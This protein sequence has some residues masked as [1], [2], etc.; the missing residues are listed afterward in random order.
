MFARYSFKRA[1]FPTFHGFVPATCCP[2][3]LPMRQSVGCLTLFFIGLE[4]EGGVEPPLS[5]MLLARCSVYGS[6]SPRKVPPNERLGV[7][8][9]PPVKIPPNRRFGGD[10]YKIV[11]I[12]AL[13]IIFTS[14][15]S[16]SIVLTPSGIFTRRPPFRPLFDS[17]FKLLTLS[18]HFC[19]CFSAAA[20]SGTGWNRTT[21]HL[22]VLIRL[23]VAHYLL[24]VPCARLSGL[25]GRI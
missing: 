6:F 4:G 15:I 22:G 25:S 20:D 9:L 14:R 2:L 18:W 3:P 7:G 19:R 8:S 12:T 21:A 1:T 5:G 11:E 13:A 16:L 23:Q 10:W 17:L 24:S